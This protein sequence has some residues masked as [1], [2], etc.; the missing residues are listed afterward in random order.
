MAVNNKRPGKG[1]SLICFPD[2][3]IVTDIE[4][5]G[6]YPDNSEIIE[7]S[8]LK[9]VSGVKTDVFS[10][11][12]KPRHSISGFITGLTGINNDM[13]KNA[14]DISEAIMNFYKFIGNDIIIGYNVNFDINF[15]YDN[16]LACHDIVL[17]NDF[18]DVLRIARRILNNIP[19]HKQT[20]VAE[21]YGISIEGAH[22]A[23]NDCEI[24]NACYLKLQE[25]IK[26]FYGSL[27][28]FKK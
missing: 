27:D 14:P 17:K 19:D 16:L 20:T 13:V 8:A 10:T 2:T 26:R 15:L 3:Y 6:L 23:E 28:M 1:K 12:V 9:Y 7:I 22:R 18:V 11:L 25:D 24:C 4:T 5:T 21:Y